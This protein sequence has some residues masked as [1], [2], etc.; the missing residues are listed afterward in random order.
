MGTAIKYS[1]SV[2]ELE[3]KGTAYNIETAAV[4]GM[5]L[6]DVINAANSAVAKIKS[7]GKPYLLVC[8][9]Y[10]FRAHSMFDAEL[11]RDKKEV[12]EW[13]KSDP[14]PQFQNYLLQEKLITQSEI[15]DFENKIETKIQKAVEFAEAGTWESLDELTRFVY[16]E[17]NFK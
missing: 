8:N 15:T 12:E 2:T 14:I 10:R 6:L 3:K 7:D 4:N 9:T 5:N 16:S 13:K 11:Y 1:H 17:S